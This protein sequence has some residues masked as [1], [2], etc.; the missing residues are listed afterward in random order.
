[1]AARGLGG[2]AD[3][4][5]L[6]PLLLRNGRQD[7][8]LLDGPIEI[9]RIGVALAVGHR[10]GGG[11]RS[12]G[13]WRSGDDPGGAVDVHP[14]GQLGRGVGQRGVAARGLGGQVDGPVL[15][16][17]LL[18]NGRQDQFLFDGPVETLRSGVVLVVGHR[19]LGFARSDRGGRSGDVPG[20]AVDVQPGGQAG[21]GVGQRG[22]APR[23]LGGQADRPVL[24]PLLLR[25]GRQDQFRHDGPGEGFAVGVAI[26]VGDG[27]RGG[28]GTG[29]GRGT[30]DAEV[31]ELHTRRQSAYSVV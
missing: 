18:R 25:N 9:L 29:L 3:R 26:V 1:M 28:A 21:R 12:D 11:V 24:H 17:L 19:H 20:G 8:F 31:R 16:P 4:P 30:G 22:L 27:H 2:Q 10:H 14:G 5:V 13:G 23:G 7:Q 6:H 15:H